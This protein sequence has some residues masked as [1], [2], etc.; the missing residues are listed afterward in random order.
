M[1]KRKAALTVIEWL[2]GIVIIGSIALVLCPGIILTP[3]L[4]A[5]GDS[6]SGAGSKWKSPVAN[7][8]LL[9]ANDSI[10]TVRAT[11]NDRKLHIS[12]GSEYSEVGSSNPFDQGLNMTSSPSFAGL[13]LGL[14]SGWAT[15]MFT[16]VGEGATKADFGSLYF[17]DDPTNYPYFTFSKA[18]GTLDNA[19]ALAQ[20]DV[21]ASFGWN[22]YDGSSFSP[23]ASISASVDNSPTPGDIAGKIIFKTSSG[24]GI[25]PD[26]R[27]SIG[28]DGKV[29]I[30]GTADIGALKIANL[31][32]LTNS[33][34]F[35]MCTAADCS[36]KCQAN[37]SNG[38]IMSCN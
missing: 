17:D 28:S 13:N 31:T 14:I 30:N 5:D 34:G 3:K 22:G 23:I 18:R 25:D 36:S 8:S 15:D 21:V 6:Y 19:T 26:E 24:S 11:L 12:N 16:A 7:S 1:Y 27:M 35:W 2:V 20:N 10:G 33:T 4:F 9:P 29:T 37:I 32:P 38:V